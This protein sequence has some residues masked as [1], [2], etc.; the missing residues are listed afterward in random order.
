MGVVEIPAKLRQRL[1][2]IETRSLL[3]TALQIGGISGR[4]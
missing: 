3:A 1:A 4:N 2:N